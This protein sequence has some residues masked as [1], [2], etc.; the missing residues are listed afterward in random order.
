MSNIE[1]QEHLG[2]DLERKELYFN[3]WLSSAALF[4]LVCLPLIPG[5]LSFASIVAHF[6]ALLGI[7]TWLAYGIAAFTAIGVEVLGLV[8]VK[9]A[10][11]MRKFNQRATGLGIEPAPLTQGVMV[12][13]LY[14][15][16]VLALVVLLKVWSSLAIWALIPLA[17]LGAIADWSF[18]LQGD[19]T[20]REAQLRKLIA[21][22]EVERN[23]QTE[24]ERLRALV[25]ERDTVIATMQDGVKSAE[26]R[27]A[28]LTEQFAKE[29]A[30]L[31]AEIIRLT[32]QVDAL[33]SVRV[34]SGA[35]NLPNSDT[36]LDAGRDKAHAQQRTAR[37]H[38]QEELLR[39]LTLEFNGAPSDELNKT[40]I[41]ERLGTTRQTIGRDI[42]ELIAAQRLSVNGHIEV[43][44]AI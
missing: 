2:S 19:Q 5:S 10:L 38:R 14:L 4:G 32:A 11:R 16:V 34:T 25:A 39:L 40:A 20:E 26:Q 30:Q 31:N 44:N 27:N 37:A 42:E 41:A 1:L 28:Q 13:G 22:Q 23:Q 3:H 12:S 33:K 7:P 6:P 29:S 21:R 36:L 9:L 43:L 15:G 24:I 17:C 8:V 35:A 18:A